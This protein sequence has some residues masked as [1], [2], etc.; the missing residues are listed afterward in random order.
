MSEISKDIQYS[1]EEAVTLVKANA[2]EK[3]DASVEIHMRLGIDPRK[4]DQQVR[5]SVVLPHGSGKTVRVAVFADGA[6][7]KEAKDAGADLVGA[8]EL[9]EEISST[10][11][12][13]F[14]VAIAHPNMMPKLAKI[15]KL[16]GPRGMMPSPKDDTVTPNIGK[17]VTEVKA[18]KVSFKNDDT[19]NIHSVIG[20]VSFSEEQ[21]IENFKEFVANIRRLKP[22]SSKGDY[23]KSV[24]I[25]SSM[26]KG[27]KISL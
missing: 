17:A 12:L 14:D 9:I 2:K 18:G 7:A 6:E 10:G 4:G 5:G 3:F 13:D 8:E 24:S 1:I 27:A 16:L 21:L 11:K 22:S 19:S 23:I 20:K 25:A 15:A 26:G